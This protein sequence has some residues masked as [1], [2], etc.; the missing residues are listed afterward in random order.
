[1]NA[2]AYCL[3]LCLCGSLIFT[4]ALPLRVDWDLSSLR[5]RGFDSMDLLIKIIYAILG[6]FGKCEPCFIY[7]LLF[8]MIWNCDYCHCDCLYYSGPGQL[9]KSALSAGC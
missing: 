6:L 5:L 3:H 9:I 1:M 8:I 4:G 2:I 7:F